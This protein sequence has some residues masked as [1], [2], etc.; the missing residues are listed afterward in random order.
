MSTYRQ[1][2]VDEAGRVIG[3]PEY[4]E[5]AN[6]KAAI[7][8]ARSYEREQDVEVWVASRLVHSIARG[9]K[10]PQLFFVRDPDHDGGS[11]YT[12]ESASDTATDGQIRQPALNRLRA[13]EVLVQAFNWSVEMRYEDECRAYARECQWMA[14]R[15]RDERDKASWLKLAQLWRIELNEERR[16]ETYAR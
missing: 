5:A 13:R 3:P 1:Y 7:E 2:R 6:D 4:F 16:R 8:H 11:R 10:E 9:R 14:E 12:P 15:T